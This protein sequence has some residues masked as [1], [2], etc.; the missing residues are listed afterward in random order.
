[1][2]DMARGGEREARPPLKRERN[3]RSDGKAAQKKSSTLDSSKDDLGTL[4]DYELGKFWCEEFV[5]ILS[6]CGVL[7]SVYQLELVLV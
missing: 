6:R 4:S 7:M 1:M 3:G 5:V 2:Q